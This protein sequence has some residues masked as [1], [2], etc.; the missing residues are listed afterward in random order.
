LSKEAGI[1]SYR[2]G[3]ELEIVELLEEVF[4]G[5]PKLGINS[6]ASD[7]WKWKTVSRSRAPQ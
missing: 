1:R 4:D 6:N 5:W 7:Y 3:D 2:T